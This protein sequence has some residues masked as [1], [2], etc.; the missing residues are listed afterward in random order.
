MVITAVYAAE[1]RADLESVLETAHPE[2]VADWSRSRGPARGVYRGRQEVTDF[3]AFPHEAF[4]EL[5]FFHDEFIP[6]DDNTVIRIGGMKGKG[7]G[8]GA[9][10]T[11]RGATAW[12]FEGDKVIR[13]TIYQDREEALAAV[14]SG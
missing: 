6:A 13:V 10:V 5:E 3:F 14:Q 8:S 12:E 2:V 7:R 11:A 4:D 1:A 9:E